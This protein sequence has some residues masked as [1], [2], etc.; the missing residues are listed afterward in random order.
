MLSAQIG[1]LAF[2][3]GSSFALIDGLGVP[4]QAYGLL[5]ATVMLGQIGDRKS[6]RLNSSH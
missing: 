1:I 2:V 4:A 6:T 3:S 5:F